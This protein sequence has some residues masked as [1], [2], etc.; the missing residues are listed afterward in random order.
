MTANKDIKVND[1]CQHDI[2]GPVKVLRLIPGTVDVLIEYKTMPMWSKVHD[3]NNFHTTSKDILTADLV[4]GNYSGTAAV[5]PLASVE[6]EGGSLR[7][8]SGKTQVREIDPSFILGIG[9]VLTKSR[10]KYPEG[11]WMKETKFSTPYESAQRHLLKFWSGE[12]ID[13][14]TLKSHLLHAATNL[15]FLYYHQNSGVGI[16]DRLFKKDKK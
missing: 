15:M 3:L 7:F 14:E 10:E 5:D 16:D 11:N 9:E 13:N 8:N 1:I 12:E 2:L 4:D 6:P